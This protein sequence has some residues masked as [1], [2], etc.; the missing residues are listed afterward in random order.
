MPRIN[1]RMKRWNEWEMEKGDEKWGWLIEYPIFKLFGAILMG[2]LAARTTDTWK[3]ITTTLDIILCSTFD[4]SSFSNQM[5]GYELLS[6][7][8]L[9]LDGR[10]SG[11]LRRVRSKVGIFG[12]ADGSAYF[13]QVLVLD[14]IFILLIRFVV[15]QILFIIIRWYFRETRKSFQQFTVHT[16]FGA[17]SDPRKWL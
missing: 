3:T 16:K 9:R 1:F 2:N 11:E 15:C 13:E 10:R 17:A 7:Q 5:A 4:K 8:G 14:I 12:Q 6:D